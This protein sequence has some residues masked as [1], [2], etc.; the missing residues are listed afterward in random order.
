MTRGDVTEEVGPLGGLVICQQGERADVVGPVTPHA[1]PVKDRGDVRGVG[2]LL[3]LCRDPHL[4]QGQP[5]AA[6]S[7][8]AGARP[9]RTASMA[10]RSSC[11]RAALRR[12]PS[13][14]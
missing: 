12:R 1:P 10:S 4:R 3:A 7:A 13:P 5:N 9:A 11:E 8:T 14:E 6:A 2:D